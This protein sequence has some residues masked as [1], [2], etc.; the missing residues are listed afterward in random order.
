VYAQLTY[1]G[2][3]RDAEVLDARDRASRDRIEP[4]IAGDPQMQDELV[5][6]SVLR[7]PDGS[8]VVISVTRSE[9]GLARA[10]QVVMNTEL[11]AGEDP[12]LL[13]GPDRIEVYQVR[14]LSTRTVTA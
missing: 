8:E 11:L 14:E 13:P 2:P 3:T 1:F 4:A 5:S 7:A 10:Q 6:L 12:A 9:A